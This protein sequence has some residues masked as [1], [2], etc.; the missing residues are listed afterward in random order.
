MSYPIQL[1]PRYSVL[2]TRYSVLSFDD[3]I[4]PRQDVRRNRETDLLGCSQID[5]QL[6]FVGCSTGRSDGFLPFRILS[7][8]V[9]ARLCMSA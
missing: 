9:A 3:P 5:D 1:S 6:N 4:R 7:T 2:S 8:K